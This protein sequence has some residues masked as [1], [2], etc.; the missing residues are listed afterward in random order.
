MQKKKS[1]VSIYDEKKYYKEKV[2]PLITDLK[3]ICQ[4]KKLPMFVTVAVAN[5]EKETEFENNMVMA[6][7]GRHLT[8]NKIAQAVL[9]LQDLNI[10]PP[11][12]VQKAI[13]TLSSYLNNISSDERITPVDRKLFSNLLVDLKKIAYGNDKVKFA[14][15][16]I[17]REL[18]DDIDEI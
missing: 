13:G 4:T 16:I 14:N 2:E 18:D 3:I 9:R 17:S 12:D 7:T 15:N 10:V 1:S 8:E 11:S 5:N 6:T